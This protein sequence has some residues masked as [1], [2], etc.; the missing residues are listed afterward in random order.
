MGLGSSLFGSTA[1]TTATNTATNVS[2]SI[3]P[4]QGMNVNVTGKISGNDILLASQ[5]ASSNN[6]VTF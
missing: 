2:N 3:T 6:N 1:G 4:G 5:K